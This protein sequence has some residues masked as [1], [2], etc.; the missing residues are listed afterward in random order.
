M[1]IQYFTVSPFGFDRPVRSLRGVDSEAAKRPTRP[2]Q[3]GGKAPSDAHQHG[4]FAAPARKT[5]EWDRYWCYVRPVEFGILGPLAVWRDGQEVELGAAKQRALLAVL[6]LHA[7]E[8]MSAERLVDALWGEK[9][10][11]GP[12]KAL[13]VHVSQ[14]RKTLGEGVIETHPLGYVV[15][16]GRRR[17]RSAALRAAARRGP[18]PARRG[19]A[20]GGGRRAARGAGALARRAARRLPLRG[21]RGE[22]DRAA[23]GAAPDRAGAPARG[24]PRRR[25][26][27][28]VACRSSRRS[29]ATTRC[30]RACA[31]C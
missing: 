2:R 18:A 5:L 20:A 8:P 25:P 29:C 28:R 15:R 6:L 16:L 11:K 9:P 3:S 4:F 30:A 17:V 27:R 14:L 23:G 22:R 13:Q 12:V 31:S 21:V 26:Q 1:E 7:G 10:P 19:P 24:R